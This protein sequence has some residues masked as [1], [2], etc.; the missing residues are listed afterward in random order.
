MTVSPDLTFA[1]RITRGNYGWTNSDLTVKKFSVTAD[2]V[3]DW[4]WKLFHFKHDIYSEEAIGLIR[5]DGF[6]PGAIG[7]ILTFGEKYP[8]EQRK[9]P[10]IGLDS[11]ALVDLSRR[12]PILWYDDGVRKLSLDLFDGGWDDYGRFLGVRRR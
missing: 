11:R 5:E 2:Q 1:E 6:E 8:E 3:G 12:V 4:E 10:I 7:H 9:Y